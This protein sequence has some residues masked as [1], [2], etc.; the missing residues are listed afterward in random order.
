MRPAAL[1]GPPDPVAGAPVPEPLGVLASVRNAP[2]RAFSRR[3]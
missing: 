1:P 3:L 2:A